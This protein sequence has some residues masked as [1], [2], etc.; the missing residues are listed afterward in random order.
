V[1]LLVQP[2]TGQDLGELQSQASHRVFEKVA[3]TGDATQHRLLPVVEEEAAAV[4]SGTSG[5]LKPEDSYLG[6]LATLAEDHGARLVVVVSPVA[7]HQRSQQNVLPTTEAELIALANARGV[8]WIDLRSLHMDDSNFRADGGHM[9]KAGATRFTQELIGKLREIGALTGGPL[10]AATLPA[11]VEKIERQGN[12]ARIEKARS[13]IVDPAL[14]LWG[15]DLRAWD[16]IAHRFLY[17]QVGQVGIPV[18]ALFRGQ[19]LDAYARNDLAGHKCEPMFGFNGIATGMLLPDGATPEDVSFELDPSV[20][21]ANQKDPTW[22]VYPGTTLRWKLAGLKTGSMQVALAARAFGTTTELPTLEM[23]GEIALLQE[24]TEGLEA[25]LNF[26]NSTTNAEVLLRVPAGGPFLLVRR[27]SLD[28]EG[29]RTALASP[30]TLS[31]VDL[32]AGALSSSAP[33]PLTTPLL[34]NQGDYQSFRVPW[35]N[36][37]SCSPLRL[38]ADGVEVPVQ[39][40]WPS[41]RPTGPGLQ[42]IGDRLFFQQ[43]AQDY[44]IFLDEGR[45][46]DG[47]P[48]R[49]CPKSRWLYPGE[50]L[51]LNLNA[52]ARRRLPAAVRALHLVGEFLGGGDPEATLQVRATFK[53][54]VLLDTQTKLSQLPGGVTLVL[55][56]FLSRMDP[57]SLELEFFLSE[58]A[59]PLRLQARAIPL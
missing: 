38:R 24:G 13:R 12:I 33:P 21:D 54:E 32:F 59:A 19:I 25:S 57:A 5:A 9:Q 52:L 20:P 49:A 39:N 31:P 42:H 53:N 14:C 51:T 11:K 28:V 44:E 15:V 8:G 46:C 26:D 43:E 50:K 10:Q 22:W 48:C 3:G 35:T 23:E 56:R 55:D 37:L 16:S 18:R 7:S 1:S 2:G 58:A 45:G 17:D 27:L 30:P 47:L 34:E 40:P 41:P 6:D 36:T 29:Q 4:V